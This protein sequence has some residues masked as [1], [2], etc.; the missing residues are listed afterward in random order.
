MKGEW[1]GY[2][3]EKI[4]E[5]GGTPSIPSPIHRRY[6]PRLEVLF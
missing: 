4:Y 3:L 6:V 5:G 2:D 1:G